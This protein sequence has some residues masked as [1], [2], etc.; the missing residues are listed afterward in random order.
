MKIQ[1]NKVTWYSKVLAFMLFVALPFIG[2][3]YGAQYGET[4]AL[5]P[6]SSGGQSQ[7]GVSGS[8]TGGPDYYHNV[9]AWQIDTRPDGGFSLAHPLDFPTND[10]Y[11]ITPRTDWRIGAN[12][13]P[14]TLMLTVII[15]SA[16]EP[17]TNFADAKLTVG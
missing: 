11:S 5:S 17:Q 1:W 16:F 15:P 3:W 14:G 4:V 13:E 12:N 2:F 6:G 7:T 10:I 8:Q 9:A